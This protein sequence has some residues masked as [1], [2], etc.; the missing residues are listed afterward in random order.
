MDTFDE[1]QR[2][3]KCISHQHL[4]SMKKSYNLCLIYS[5]YLFTVTLSDVSPKSGAH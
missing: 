4:I 3:K 1:M 2:K 5:N